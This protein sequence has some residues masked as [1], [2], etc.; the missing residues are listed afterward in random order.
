MTNPRRT[1]VEPIPASRVHGAAHVNCVS[2]ETNP[3]EPFSRIY[4]A[5]TVF[6]P[7]SHV[8]HGGGYA[9]ER[10]LCGNCMGSWVQPTPKSKLLSNPG[11][12]GAGIKPSGGC[13]P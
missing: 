6:R 1:H 3:S 9:R 12:R 10:F 5:Q 8:Q 11:H 2:S 13:A 4:R 7:V